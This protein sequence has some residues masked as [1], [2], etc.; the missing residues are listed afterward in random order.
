[1]LLPHAVSFSCYLR[2]RKK[3]I[4]EG[5][6]WWLT[7]FL[8]FKCNFCMIGFIFNMKPIQLY[9]FTN[10]KNPSYIHYI[11]LHSSPETAAIKFGKLTI[12]KFQSNNYTLGFLHCWWCLMSCFKFKIFTWC[13][14]NCTLFARQ[15]FTLNTQPLIEKRARNMS[16]TSLFYNKRWALYIESWLSGYWS[17]A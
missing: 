8:K 17:L 1:M 3:S 7:Y 16:L 4:L 5:K 12:Y 9:I 11:Q 15:L 14:P 13:P 6:K 10:C 2:R